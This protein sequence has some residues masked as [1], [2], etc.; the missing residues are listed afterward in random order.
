MN[1]YLIG[2]GFKSDVF[3]GNKITGTEGKILKKL[4]QGVA[5]GSIEID[6]DHIN[7]FS[8]NYSLLSEEMDLTEFECGMYVGMLISKNIMYTHVILVDN[9][10]VYVY[11]IN[12]EAVKTFFG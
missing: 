7:V 4:L 8:V 1:K 3:N 12:S 6:I 11:G 9:D 2:L 10:C 5:S